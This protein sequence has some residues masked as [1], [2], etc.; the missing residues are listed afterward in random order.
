MLDIHLSGV[1]AYRAHGLPCFHLA[2]GYDPMLEES[3]VIATKR[4]LDICVLA[5]MTERRE[6]F[7][8]G[9]SDF[10]ARR[11][12]HIRFVPIGFAKTEETRSYL[13]VRQ[14]NS[15]LQR[16]KILLNV[17]Y[18]QLKYFEWHRAL[19]AM[20]NRCCLVTET[21]EG[22]EPLVP[23]KHFVMAKADDLT[24]CCEYYL[25]HADKREAIAEAAY[26]FVRHGLTQEANCRAFLQQLTRR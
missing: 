21:C 25:N 20:A 17:H 15:L 2:L 19:I 3:D 14:R 13:P 26:E 16:T 10:F 22:F 11:D 23:G 18:S 1:A 9:N 12:C 5:A 7:F 6:E 4:H 24:T 8:A